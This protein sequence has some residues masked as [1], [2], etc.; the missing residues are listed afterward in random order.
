MFNSVLVD[1]V[2]V[3]LLNLLSLAE[4]TADR[5]DRKPQCEKGA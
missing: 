2:R 3:S 1:T 4:V 5:S